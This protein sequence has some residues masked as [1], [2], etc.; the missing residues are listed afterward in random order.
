MCQALLHPQSQAAE[1]QA[2]HGLVLIVST[3]AELPRREQSPHLNK[4]AQLFPRDEVMS[5]SQN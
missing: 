1:P 3:Q 4:Q 2:D 5:G